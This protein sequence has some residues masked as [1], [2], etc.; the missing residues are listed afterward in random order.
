MAD[1]FDF[2]RMIECMRTNM[3]RKEVELQR[4]TQDPAL[5]E[6]AQALTD[7]LFSS[8]N[9]LFNYDHVV[10]HE[11]NEMDTVA[12]QKAL[13]VSVL[14][15]FQRLTGRAY[16]PPICRTSQFREEQRQRGQV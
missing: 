3:T 12:V 15:T 7:E 1:K 13:E 9:G 10:D 2:N 6:V 11:G 16:V 5:H 8:L 14:K 4:L